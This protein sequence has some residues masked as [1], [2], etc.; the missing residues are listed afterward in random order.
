MA[1]RQEEADVLGNWKFTVF[2]PWNRVYPANRWYIAWEVIKTRIID[3]PWDDKLGVEPRFSDVVELVKIN[4]ITTLSILELDNEW[5]L[6]NVSKTLSTR[7]RLLAKLSKIYWYDFNLLTRITMTKLNRDKLVDNREEIIEMFRDWTLT[8]AKLPERN[9]TSLEELLNAE[10]FS[11]TLINHDY[12]WITP[13][14]WNYIAEEYWLDIKNTMAI[15]DPKNLAKILEVLSKND[16]YIWWW[17]WVGFKDTWWWLLKE[18]DFWFVDPVADEMES[19]NFVAHFWDEIHWY[20][21]DASWYCESLSES[22]KKIWKTL[23]WKT[24]VLLGA[25]WTARWIAMELVNRWIA[26]IFIVNRTLSKAEYISKKLNQI[27]EW[28]A[29]SIIEDSI[30]QITENVDSIINLT[31]KWADWQFESYSWLATTEKWV[32][33]NINSTRTNLTRFA[34]S[35]KD[36]IISDINLTKTWTTPLL[37]IAR[38]LWL[39]ILDWKLMVVYQWVE[40]IWTVFWDE[41]IK[42]WWTKEEIRTKLI[43]YIFN[44]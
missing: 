31:V 32:S 7:E 12:A 23:E 43:N 30:E 1:F 22:F 37:D 14:M 17:F 15:T 36:I 4:S 8:L 2:R 40:A 24:I 5:V 38:E 33:E 16:R 21:S 10:H 6:N 39:N 9:I 19:V 26:K 42:K 13:K 27:R 35:N 28:V 34:E 41:I 11:I 29:V 3:V 44:K 18:K 20:N 25:W